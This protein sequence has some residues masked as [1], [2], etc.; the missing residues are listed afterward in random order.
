MGNYYEKYK[1]LSVMFMDMFCICGGR[2]W[3]VDR[4]NCLYSMTPGLEDIRLE[5]NLDH[6][7]DGRDFQYKELIEYKQKLI[8][9]P[10]CGNAVAVFDTDSG[11]TQFITHNKKECRFSLNSMIY[12]DSLYL[13]FTYSGRE[14]YRV[15]LDK[16]EFICVNEWKRLIH[17]IDLNRNDVFSYNHIQHQDTA[18]MGIY[19]TNRILAYCLHSGK[20]EV[21]H[22]LPENFMIFQLYEDNRGNYLLTHAQKAI[23]CVCHPD[24]GLSEI[25]DFKSENP[26]ISIETNETTLFALPRGENMIYAYDYDGRN[27]EEIPVDT[28]DYVDE[29]VL[30]RDFKLQQDILYIAASFGIVALDIHSKEQRVYPMVKMEG[31]SG[32]EILIREQRLRQGRVSMLREREKP[33]SCLLELVG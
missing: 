15:D 22:I 24:S 20:V 6:W 31:L 19:K 33:L 4:A 7:E 5:A 2:L 30:L 23:V 8:C 27:I 11:K 21:R 28:A 25:I 16:G 10:K 29:Q 14:L 13:F 1:Y 32:T 17:D 3:M 26:I 12:E 18:V 9:I